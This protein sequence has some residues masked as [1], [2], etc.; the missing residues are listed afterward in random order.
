MKIIAAFF[1]LLVQTSLMAQ[2]PVKQTVAYSRA[3]I[4]GIPGN[5]TPFPPA[6]FIYVVINKGTPISAT[7]ICLRGTRY[8]ATLRRV[9]SPIVV[10]H[11][12]SVPTGKKD[13]LVK[14]TPDDVYQVDVGAAEG[15]CTQRH[16][17]VVCLASAG[18]RWYGKA[19]KIQPLKPAA[20]M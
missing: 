17:V 2:S 10:D 14:R 19:T 12:V 20:A 9:S 7:S 5:Q 13:T 18:S 6:Y 3:T 11:D 16:E 1:L 4:S 15:S 8:P